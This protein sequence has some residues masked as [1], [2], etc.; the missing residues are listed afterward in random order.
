M[1]LEDGRD[2]AVGSWTVSKSI[3]QAISSSRDG[4]A[5]RVLV[6]SHPNGGG[7]DKKAR[8]IAIDRLLDEI[9]VHTRSRDPTARRWWS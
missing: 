2:G 7:S 8:S 3:H 6:G 5:S 4:M 1:N 9:G